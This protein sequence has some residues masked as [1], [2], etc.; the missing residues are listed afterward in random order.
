[1][2]EP[3]ARDNWLHV[4]RNNQRWIKKRGIDSVVLGRAYS[5]CGLAH[6]HL[7]DYAQARRYLD[8]SLIAHEDIGV[9]VFMA[10]V[11]MAQG[12]VAEGLE[13]YLIALNREPWYYGEASDAAAAHGYQLTLTTNHRRNY[14]LRAIA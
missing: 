12:N 1:M 5:Y 10:R 7:G 2:S 3:T 4:L 9:H 6:Y 8:L 14:A 13:H 11:L